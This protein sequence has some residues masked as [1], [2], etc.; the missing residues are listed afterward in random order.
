MLTRIPSLKNG[1]RTVDQSSKQ[2]K[3][4]IRWSLQ[5]KK[6]IFRHRGEPSNKEWLKIIQYILRA[7]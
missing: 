2:E 1:V 5:G 7:V 4:E 3:R 6:G